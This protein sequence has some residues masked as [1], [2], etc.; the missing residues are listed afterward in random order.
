MLLRR[1]QE[2]PPSGCILSSSPTSGVGLLL[3]I[4]ITRTC[5]AGGIVRKRISIC[6]FLPHDEALY[7]L[8]LS[9]AFYSAVHLLVH[10]ITI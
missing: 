1:E 9:T 3:L 2:T 5:T 6:R 8:I 4:E 7:G 10:Y